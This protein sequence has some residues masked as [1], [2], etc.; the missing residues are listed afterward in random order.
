MK[1]KVVSVFIFISLCII[2]LATI[3]DPNKELTINEIFAM[4]KKTIYLEY[5][6]NINNLKE[7][8]ILGPA[9]LKNT[10]ARDCAYTDRKKM[11]KIIDYLNVIPLVQA[12]KNELPNKSPDL[13]IRFFDIND[14]IVGCIYIY[15]Q[16]FIEDTYTGEL[17]RSKNIHIIEG[18][19]N[20]QFGTQGDGSMNT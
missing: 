13:S 1:K 5:E 7:I 20:I 10:D 6:Q 16:V 19:E 18:L 3:A 11:Q 17:Y 9:T 14:N 15:G 4:F 2:I 8:D 12:N